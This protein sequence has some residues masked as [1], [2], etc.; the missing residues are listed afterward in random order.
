MAFGGEPAF[1]ARADV[2][3]ATYV[4]DRDHPVEVGAGD[5]DHLV[6]W[7]SARLGRPVR[8]PSLDEYGYQL[9]GGRLLPGEAGPAA[10]LMYQRADGA[11]VTLYMTAYDTRRLA[12]QAMSAGDRYTYF[13][14]DRGMGY[15]LSGQATNGACANSRSTR[16]ANSAAR[17][18]R[19]RG[20]ARAAA[21]R[22]QVMKMTMTKR[23]VPMLVLAALAAGTALAQADGDAPLR[24]PVDADGVQRW[25]SSAAAISSDRTT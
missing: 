6:A 19:G 1:A 9:L 25:R 4:A 10:Q 12:P 24:V 18:T 23:L 21:G 8:A 7:L 3:Y 11:R 15:A 22:E 5:P 13:W 2:A 17:P 14:S 20:D 16:A